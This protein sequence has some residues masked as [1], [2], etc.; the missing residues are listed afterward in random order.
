MYDYKKLIIKEYPC[1]FFNKIFFIYSHFK[2]Y[3]SFFMPLLS[4]QKIHYPSFYG[5]F[6]LAALVSVYIVVEGQ[7]RSVN[8]L[9]YDPN[10]YITLIFSVAIALALINYIH[11]VSL[12][13]DRWYPWASY[14]NKRLAFQLLFCALIPIYFDLVLIKFF[15][16]LF[17][18]DFKKSAYLTSEFP[19]AK[20]L[21]YLMNIWYMKIKIGYTDNQQTSEITRKGNDSRLNETIEHDRAQVFEGVLGKKKRVFYVKELNYFKREAGTGKASLTDG[22]TWFIDFNTREIENLLDPDQFIKINRNVILSFNLIDSYTSDCKKG[23]VILKPDVAFDGDKSITRD[24]FQ[25]F[26]IAFKKFVERQ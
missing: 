1:I 14:F 15:F 2:Q 26:K 11:Q 22:T 19:L 23:E 6:I 21:I 16:W 3:I 17:M 9:V 8:E 12:L 18:Q 5:R 4:D 25:E 10:V 24:Q 7:V 13:L 20:M